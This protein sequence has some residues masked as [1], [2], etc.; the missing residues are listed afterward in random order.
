MWLTGKLAPLRRT[1]VP[2][3]RSAP[4][5]SFVASSTLQPN[6]VRQ[7]WPVSGFR[8]R[9]RQY[10]TV[11]IQSSSLARLDG[12]PRRGVAVKRNADDVGSVS[13]D[14]ERASVVLLTRWPEGSPA[15]VHYNSPLLGVQRLSVRAERSITRE[16]DTQQFAFQ[17]SKAVG[18]FYDGCERPMAMWERGICREIQWRRQGDQPLRRHPWVRCATLAQKSATWHGHGV[19]GRLGQS[20]PRVGRISRSGV[21]DVPRLRLGPLRGVIKK[22][23]GEERPSRLWVLV[24]LA[25]GDS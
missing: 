18:D 20:R 11:F 13:L 24:R 22:S 25:I 14:P 15:L 2:S 21:V 3:I 7:I 4:E 10:S 17:R 16:C 19:V 23:L 8:C 9:Q 1:I 6:M 5:Y 12:G